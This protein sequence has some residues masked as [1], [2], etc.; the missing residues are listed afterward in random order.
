MKGRLVLALLLA[1]RF[2]PVQAADLGYLG[3]PGTYSEQAA[4]AYR[5]AEPA[6]DT[7]HALPSITTVAGAVA[8]G[9]VQR[10]L[11]PGLSTTAG[12][13]AE[14]HLALLRAHDPGFRILGAVIVPI[15]TDLLVRPGTRL[16]DIRAVL[17]HPN[18]LAEAGGFLHARLPG[19]ALRQ[20]ASTAAA[21]AMVAA[22][23]G[24]LAAIASPAAAARYGLQRLAPD[25]EDDPRNATLFWVIAPASAAI[26]STTA[27]RIAVILDAPAGTPAFSALV[28]ALHT[29]G[30]TVASV[31]ARPLRGPLFGWRYML[32]LTAATP[33][34]EA[35]IA[36]ALAASG[37][38]APALLLGAWRARDVI[39]DVIAPGRAPATL[40]R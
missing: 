28:L 2:T 14:S 24:S 15:E 40:P 1:M 21:A 12:F 20:V 27:D 4:D 3:P 25:I 8:R 17:S 19:V 7:L 5:A 16:A 31:D 33:Q 26:P 22:S 30:F 38:D 9:E 35:A 29:A 39:A 13:P 11:L 6:F 10:G 18:A 34:P 36:T 32:V 23:D 37:R